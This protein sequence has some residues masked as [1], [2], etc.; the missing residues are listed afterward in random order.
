MKTRDSKNKIISLNIPIE[1]ITSILKEL[2]REDKEILYLFLEEELVKPDFNEPTMTY[3]ASEKSLSKD[4][5]R[6]EEDEAWKDL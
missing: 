1:D 3:L 6:T 2:S 5:S 4:W